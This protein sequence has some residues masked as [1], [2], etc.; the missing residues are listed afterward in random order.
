MMKGTLC[1]VALAWLA[2]TA[3][4]QP[5]SV[6]FDPAKETSFD[7]QRA[8]V[9]DGQSRIVAEGGVR[10]SQPGVVL[11]SDRMEITRNAETEEIDRF[12]ATGRVRYASVSGDAIAGDEALYLST[13]NTL[14]VTGNVVL[15]QD[16]QIATGSRL[17]YNTKTG[18]ITLTAEAGE[19]VR[20]LLP[21]R[22]GR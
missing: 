15:L 12:F 13:E 20:G 2:G 3:A 9:L 19:R 14:V 16:G 1:A 10:I 7:A 4:A 6:T 18:A 17:V 22:Q 21:Q 8:E 5:A 11:T